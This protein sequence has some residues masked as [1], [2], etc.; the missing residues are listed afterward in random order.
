LGKEKAQLWAKKRLSF[1]Q[2]KGS[3]LGKEKAQL[4]AKKKL[5][6]LSAKKKPLWFL[7]SLLY[8]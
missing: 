4:W 1:G 7:V 2:R 5:Y 6:E 8:I 3:A